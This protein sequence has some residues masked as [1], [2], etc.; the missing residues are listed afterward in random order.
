MIC[1]SDDC[2]ERQLYFLAI[3]KK[4]EAS[5]Y[6]LAVKLGVVGAVKDLLTLVLTR[7][8]LS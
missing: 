6:D 3:V 4:N 1:F 5:A 8:T 7:I 2:N